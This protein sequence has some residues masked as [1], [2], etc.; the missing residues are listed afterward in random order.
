MIPWAS[1]KAICAGSAVTQL[2]VHA[3]QQERPAV[4]VRH[5]ID[6]ACRKFLQALPDFEQ[7]LD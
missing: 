1:S 4:T 3:S 5:R 2:F 7:R 6:L